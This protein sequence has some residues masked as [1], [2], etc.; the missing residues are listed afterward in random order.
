[1]HKILKKFAI[2]P[3]Q[4]TISWDK[5]KFTWIFLK[6]YYVIDNVRFRW[7]KDALEFSTR[8]LKDELQKEIKELKEKI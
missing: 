1:M 6:T 5:Y 8:F 4:V 7:R 3:T 2:W